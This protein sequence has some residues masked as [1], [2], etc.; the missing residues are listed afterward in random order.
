MDLLNLLDRPIAFHRCLVEP[1]GS[2]N[3]ALMLSQALYWSKRTRDPRGWFYKS[4]D[5]W[6]EET[7]MTRRA[8]EFA[9]KLLQKTSFW[10]EELRGV[11]ATLHYRIDIENLKAS[12]DVTLKLDSTKRTNKIER[13]VETFT[14]SETT[15]ETTQKE[16]ITYS[17]HNFSPPG[18]KVFWEAYPYKR[19]SDPQEARNAW[20]KSGFA[21][22]EW[23]TVLAGLELWKASDEW[24]DERLIPSPEK[25]IRG[26]R[27][28]T[29]PPRK[30]IKGKDLQQQLNEL[31]A[32]HGLG[33]QAQ[34]N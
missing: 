27:W 33:K 17:G 19:D 20:F 22:R 16:N 2:V 13:N 3:A 11:P 15:T 34:P 6:E 9:R 24:K 18:F 32:K 29:F 23:E 31:E 28:Q 21:E 1:A 10:K 14:S 25:F 12:F 7:G 5:E 4:A 8:Q 26:K 30:K